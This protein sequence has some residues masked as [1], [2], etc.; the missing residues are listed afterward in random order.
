MGLYWSAPY[1]HDGG[2]AVGR[3]VDMQIGLP[4]TLEKNIMP[5]P[6]NSLMALVDRNLRSR[7]VEAN[8]S[9]PDLRRMN[10]QGTGH[11]YWV[12]S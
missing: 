9:S 6:I 3:N 7:V 4:G 2:V 12:D 1:L 11:N 5:D 10:V 8:E